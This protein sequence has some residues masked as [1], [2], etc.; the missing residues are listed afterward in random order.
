LEHRPQQ[1]VLTD[2]NGVYRFPPLLDGQVTV[3]VVAEGWVPEMCKLTVARDITPLD[4][5]L[6]RGKTLRIKFVDRA[7]LPV[8]NVGVGIESWRGGK[9]LYNYKHPNVVDSHIP[10]QADAS[11]VYE[12]SWA[13]DDAVTYFFGTKDIGTVSG[14]AIK[15]DDQEHVQTLPIH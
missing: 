2:Q 8:P 4:F 6:R 9:S 11:G 3:T 1:E 14:V 10:R 5:Q 13:P 12:W 15:A 7:G